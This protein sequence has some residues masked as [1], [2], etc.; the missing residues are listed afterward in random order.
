MALDPMAQ[1]EQ[2]QLRGLLSLATDPQEAQAIQQ[3]LGL[4]D[5]TE[6]WT[7]QRMPTTSELLS[8]AVAPVSRGFSGLFDS[9]QNKQERVSEAWADPKISKTEAL[10]QTAVNAGGAGVDLI[11]TPFTIAA[12]YAI[13]GTIVGDT[14]NKGIEGGLK[15]ALMTDAGKMLGEKWEN[16]SEQN[17]RRLATAGIATDVI[18]TRLGFKGG[19]NATTR[20]A[21][22]AVKDFYSGNPVKKISG[23]LDSFIKKGVPNALQEAVSPQAQANLSKGLTVGLQDEIK[24]IVESV[25]HFDTVKT[26]LAASEWDPKKADFTPEQ[27]AAYQHMADMGQ[28]FK[29]VN[30]PSTSLSYIDGA[31]IQKLYMLKQQGR[32][33]G[34]L[35]GLVQEPHALFVGTLDDTAGIVNALKGDTNLPLGVAQRFVEIDQKTYSSNRKM[36]LDPWVMPQAKNNHVVVRT[37][38][39]GASN[40]GR[41]QMGQLGSRQGGFFNTFNN[42]VSENPQEA[43]YRQV[44]KKEKVVATAKRNLDKHP[45]RASFLKNYQ[46]KLQDLNTLKYDAAN[47]A[48]EASV[49]VTLGALRKQGITELTPETLKYFAQASD[50]SPSDQAKYVRLK[51]IEN[52]TSRERE[53]IRTLERKKPKGKGGGK[54][55]INDGGGYVLSKPDADGYY[56]MVGSHHSAAKELGGVGVKIAINPSSGQVYTSIRDGHDM[57]GLNPVGGKGLV[58][59]VQPSGFNMYDMVKKGK[60]TLHGTPFDA[61]TK[62]KEAI[63]K[64]EKATGLTAPEKGSANAVKGDMALTNMMVEVAKNYN[65]PVRPQDYLRAGRNVA[66]LGYLAAQGTDPEKENIL[67]QGLMKPPRSF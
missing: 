2:Q 11:N 21:W 38:A 35:E 19:V 30:K 20:N 51:S 3:Q 33:I 52:P 5:P 55:S 9:F 40:L 29:D 16:L 39:G 46:E 61:S 65:A 6:E 48:T 63:V 60:T 13:P 42:I 43:L 15:S 1:A 22:I 58:T 12:D 59:I 57:L 62:A 7:A 10:A 18:L 44:A 50:L 17:K 67:P 4:I 64:T 56:Y 34:I 37:A 27:A 36:S 28:G 26:K 8:Y 31:M 54:K 14:I 24:Q 53:S 32:D 47:A 23:T 66:G 41:E 49:K 45:N 25:K